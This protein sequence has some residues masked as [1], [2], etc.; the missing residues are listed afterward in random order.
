MMV[1]DKNYGKERKRNRNVLILVL[2][3][4]GLGQ[5]RNLLDGVGD[6]CL[7]PCSIGW[8]SWTYEPI[9]H[10]LDMLG[11]N[12]C[13]IGWWSWT[14]IQQ[15]II[16]LEHVSLN[17]C[18]IGWWSWTEINFLCN[19]LLTCL[20]PCSIGWWS[21]TAEGITEAG[22][23]GNCLNPCSIGWWSWTILQSI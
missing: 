12:P 2:L 17:P 19:F 7:N 5:V 13:S 8:W 16:M 11:L 20:N 9:L 10:L 14:G 21:W 23:V 4:D 6:G 18:S 1:L 3:D 22:E 15:E